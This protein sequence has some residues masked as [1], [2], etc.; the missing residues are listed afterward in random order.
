MGDESSWFQ[1][2]STWSEKWVS[3]QEK[4][5]AYFPVVLNTISMGNSSAPTASTED[6]DLWRQTILPIIVSGN[7]LLIF[8]ELC[9]HLHRA[10]SRY[11]TPLT[12]PKWMVCGQAS[13]FF[14]CKVITL[15]SAESA[16]FFQ[17]SKSQ[18]ECLASPQGG[19]WELLGILHFWEMLKTEHY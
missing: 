7:C 16:I 18:L 11:G 5:S 8:K 12:H 2:L 1:H 9:R 17:R 4:W 13:F 14:H 3:K 10:I 15:N 19:S 6:Q